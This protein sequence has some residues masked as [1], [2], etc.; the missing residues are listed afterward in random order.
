MRERE[1]SLCH[2]NGQVLVPLV[3]IRS[4]LSLGLGRERD[5]VG[6]VHLFRDDLDL[7]LDRQLEV[8]QELERVGRRARID[9][10]LA[11]VDR[12][13]ASLGPVVARDGG[14]GAG[15]ER[16]LLDESDLGRSVGPFVFCGTRERR[17][18]FS[19]SLFF[20]ATN[21]REPVD[22][23]DDLDTELLGVLNVLGEVRATLLENF[24]VLVEVHLGERFAR[25]HVGSTSVHLERANRR[26]E[27]DRVRVETRFATLDVAELFHPVRATEMS[28]PAR[29]SF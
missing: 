9:H 24:E 25:S 14:I 20:R 1:V 26:D 11:E 22:G 17:S 8:V 27:D 13:L 4:D 12:A 29:L 23:D 21:S 16:L 2:A 5:A 15:S 10:G 28:E 3:R 6:A 18:D 7:V 19:V